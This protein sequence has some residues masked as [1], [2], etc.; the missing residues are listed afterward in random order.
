MGMATAALITL[1]TVSA[2]MSI[3]GGYAKAREAER[4]SEYNA[5]VYEQQAKMIEAQKKLE[6]GQYSR[7]IG[8]A[9][10]K[11]IAR[12]AKAGLM[13]S[14]SPMAVI[15]D[16]ETQM[17][18]DMS[19]GQYNLEAKKRYATSGAAEYG[20]QGRSSA[21]LNIFSGFTSAFTTLLSAGVSYS[22]RSMTPKLN[23]PGRW[24]QIGSYKGYRKY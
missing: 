16:T 7:K 14:G 12:T 21:R 22:A 13:L 15:V 20:R 3:A 17:L 6:A 19:V 11:A 2:G 23:P 10:G 18:L 24:N 4:S 9:R 8:R 1:A 5:K